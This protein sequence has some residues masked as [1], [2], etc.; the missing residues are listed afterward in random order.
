MSNV[1]KIWAAG[2]WWFAIEEIAGLLGLSIESARVFCS[3][4]SSRGEIV[5]LKNGIYILPRSIS[6]TSEE[7]RF[8]LANF[9]QSPSYISFLTALSFYGISTQLVSS[10]CESVSSERSANYNAEGFVFNFVKFPKDFMKG[11][12]RKGNIFIA[13]KEKAMADAVYLSSLGRYALDFEAINFK[14][15]DEKEMKKML[16]IFP[17]RTRDYFAKRSLK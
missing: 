5:R 7:E 4:A 8:R 15:F 13:S 2:K 10:A 17:K 6:K 11:F 9:L 3:R 14:M 12:Y 1:S 16:Q